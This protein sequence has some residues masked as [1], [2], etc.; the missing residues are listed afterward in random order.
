MILIPQNIWEKQLIRLG[1][2]NFSYQKTN[3]FKPQL[4]L[5]AEKQ[6]RVID[7]SFR[8]HSEFYAENI[9]VESMKHLNKE[10]EKMTW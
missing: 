5:Q 8:F 7:A 3:H 9:F 4:K 2:W 6:D 10:E 1:G